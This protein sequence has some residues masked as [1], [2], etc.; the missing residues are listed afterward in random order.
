MIEK[1]YSL[2]DWIFNHPVRM[3][4]AAALWFNAWTA[5]SLVSANALHLLNT[6]SDWLL[7]AGVG[8]CIGILLPLV[9]YAAVQQARENESERELAK[10]LA[11]LQRWHE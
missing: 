11:M 6:P 8:I 1:M 2:G 5:V 7:V 4:V 3:L 9:A 10:F